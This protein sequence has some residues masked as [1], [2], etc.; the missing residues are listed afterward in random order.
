LLIPIAKTEECP[1]NA[2]KVYERRESRAKSKSKTGFYTLKFNVE[3]N[4]TSTEM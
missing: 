3:H 2:K 1:L 4:A